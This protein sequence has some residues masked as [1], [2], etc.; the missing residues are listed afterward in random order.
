[1][2]TVT[3]NIIER[4]EFKYLID[5]ATADRVRAA[6]RPFCELDPWAARNPG[7]RYAI[8]SL[9]FDTRDLTLF[10]ANEHEQVDRF[11]ARVRHYPEVRGGPVFF[12]IK[13]RYNDVIAKT[14]GKV[15]R[16]VWQRLLTDPAAPIPDAVAGK[17]RPAV[18]RF[19][20]LARSLHLQPYTLVRYDREP[21]FSRVDDYV[22]VTFDSN[23]RAQLLQRVDF[24][25]PPHRWRALDD[26][27]TQRLC[28]PDSRIVLEIKFTN[29]IP[30]WL[31]HI[32]ERLGLLRRSFSKYGTSIRAFYETRDFRTARCAGGWR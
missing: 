31:L 28:E 14:R 6:I 1:M 16:D 29:I 20:A 12:E 26:A 9:Y 8:E 19:L 7:G 13:R 18:E 30:L 17:D 24:D 10:W 25:A 32:V 15:P 5:P 27:V 23:I 11:K 2:R 22:R 3:A 21:H 4:R